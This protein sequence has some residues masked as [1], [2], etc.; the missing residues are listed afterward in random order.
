MNAIQMAMGTISEPITAKPSIGI[1][2]I[3]LNMNLCLI[4]CTI[5]NTSHNARLI[6]FI[7]FFSLLILMWNHALVCLFAH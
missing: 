6:L 4:Q 2:A 3:G 1:K 7:Y 5:G